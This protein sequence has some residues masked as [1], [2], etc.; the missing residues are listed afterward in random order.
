M[1]SPLNALRQRA[2]RLEL[3]EGGL[4]L[5]LAGGVLWFCHYLERTRESANQ[6]YQQASR[7]HHHAQEQADRARAAYAERL[8]Q[9]TPLHSTRPEQQKQLRASLPTQG[10]LSINAH[11]EHGNWRITHYTL[12]FPTLHEDRFVQWS[13]QLLQQPGARIPAC[14]LARSESEPLGLEATCT[15][16]WYSWQSP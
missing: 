6:Q 9:L 4:I 12:Q 3:L 10:R 14:I 5:L 15:V 2:V 16:H 1:D 8:A 7:M 13:E 11:T